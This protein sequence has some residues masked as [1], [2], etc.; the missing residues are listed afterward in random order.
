MMQDHQDVFIVGNLTQNFQFFHF[1][2]QGIMIIDKEDFE[3]FRQEQR[4]FLQ[5]QIDR[6]EHQ[7]TDLTFISGNHTDQWRTDLVVIC[8]DRLRV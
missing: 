5:D 3:L 7:V 1:H 6:L 2:I 8:A 4:P